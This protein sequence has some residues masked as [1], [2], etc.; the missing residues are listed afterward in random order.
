MIP[1]HRGRRL[2]HPNT[3]DVERRTPE[4]SLY[5]ADDSR[6]PPVHHSTSQRLQHQQSITLPASTA[7]HRTVTPPYAPSVSST[8]P[9]SGIH[10]RSVASARGVEEFKVES[11]AQSRRG[12]QDGTK[13]L[14][15]SIFRFWAAVF[16]IVVILGVGLGLGLGFGLRSR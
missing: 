9:I 14:G 13:I 5:D 2:L 6:P 4:S 7:S 12:N 1:G 8:A 16:T 11:P 15:L 3:Q 10:L